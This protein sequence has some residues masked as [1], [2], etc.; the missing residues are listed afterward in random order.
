MVYST[1]KNKYLCE[2]CLSKENNDKCI[3]S[4]VFYFDKYLNQVRKCKNNLTYK[5]YDE[6]VEMFKNQNSLPIN[7]ILEA[8]NNTNVMADSVEKLDFDRK[9]KY[10]ILYGEDDEKVLWETLKR[11]YNEKVVRGEIEDNPKYWENIN[12]EMR[13]FKKIN[14]IGFML[15]MSE[16]MSWAKDNTIFCKVNFVTCN[17]LWTFC[18]LR[19]EF[20]EFS[21]DCF[22]VLDRIS[23]FTTCNVN[24][25]NKHSATFN[26]TKELMTKADTFSSTLDK[27]R[28]VSHNKALFRTH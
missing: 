24:N 1:P 9:D 26:V 27:S 6:L 21:I 18:K 28:N 3:H 8:I 2:K 23:S 22:K 10:P 11:K 19:I 13:V 12:E 7:V 14:M 25:V 15:L 20:F 4:N 5:S 17:N 16:I